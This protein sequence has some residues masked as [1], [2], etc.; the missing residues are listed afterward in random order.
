MKL[1]PSKLTATACPSTASAYPTRSISAT[2]SPAS[3][4]STRTDTQHYAGSID[5][6]GVRAS[7]LDDS[8]RQR[9]GRR[10]QE[11]AVHGDA[12]QEGPADR[13]P[14]RRARPAASTF[15]FGIS[16]YNAAAPV[17][18]PND[19]QVVPAPSAV[20]TLLNAAA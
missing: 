1:D 17:S 16:D 3:C 11:R 12:R 10:R 13:L 8:G 6:A 7:A 14:R 4:R 2:C 5:L 20:Y 15:D 19:D 9:P 18:R